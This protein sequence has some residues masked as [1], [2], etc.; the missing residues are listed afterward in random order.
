M[1]IEFTELKIQNSS[2]PLHNTGLCVA[3][4]V[5]SPVEDTE[6]LDFDDYLF[7][8]PYRFHFRNPLSFS[9]WIDGFSTAYHL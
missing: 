5:P 8:I 9:T 6:K 2:V 4:W 7:I 3:V 1:A